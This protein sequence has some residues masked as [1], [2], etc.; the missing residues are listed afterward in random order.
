MSPIRLMSID[1]IQML[2]SEIRQKR[3]E[4]ESAAFIR[5]WP[6]RAAGLAQLNLRSLPLLRSLGQGS[7]R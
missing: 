5:I 1:E 4:I 6:K 2:R 3:R 7:A